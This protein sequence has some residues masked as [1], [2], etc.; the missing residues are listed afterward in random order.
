MSGNS[1]KN[2]ILSTCIYD[3]TTKMTVPVIYD[4]IKQWT[5]IYFSMP[6][7]KI[8][9]WVPKQLTEKHNFQ[10][11]GISF[12]LFKCY[13]ESNGEF[14]QHMFMGDKTWTPHIILEAKVLSMNWPH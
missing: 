5:G 9:F 2:L 4:A 6:G 13:R 8:Q 7:T 14:L 10:Y 1:Q 3:A 12:G 11:M